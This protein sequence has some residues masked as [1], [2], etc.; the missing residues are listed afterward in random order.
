MALAIALHN[1]PEG[2]IIAAPIYA[3]TGNRWKAVGL[4]TASVRTLHSHSHCSAAA[5]P[6]L[7]RTRCAPPTPTHILSKRHG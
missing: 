6:L 3:A 1:I 7:V 2:V 4:A 5:T